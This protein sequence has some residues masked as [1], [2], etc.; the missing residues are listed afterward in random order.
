[1]LVP[2]GIHILSRGKESDG[3]LDSD[4]SA[5]LR[6]IVLRLTCDTVACLKYWDSWKFV[7]TAIMDWKTVLQ[8]R[9]GRTCPA[10]IMMQQV[11]LKCSRFA[12]VD[13]SW[14]SSFNVVTGL[15]TG[16]LEN[17]GLTVGGHSFCCC[18]HVVPSHEA[19][20]LCCTVGTAAGG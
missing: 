5:I 19:H 6:N 16:R 7:Q 8:D 3:H 4:S 2:L 12:H 10:I 17:H 11:S 18:H 20:P 1:V 9:V 14:V 13:M 15:Q